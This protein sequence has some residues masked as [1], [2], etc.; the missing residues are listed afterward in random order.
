M[1]WRAYMEMMV[2]QKMQAQAYPHHTRI[3]TALRGQIVVAHKCCIE[4]NNKE[5]YCKGQAMNLSEDWWPDHTFIRSKRKQAVTVRTRDDSSARSKTRAYFHWSSSARQRPERTVIC[6]PAEIEGPTIPS[7][8]TQWG[9]KAQVFLHASLG[10]GWWFERTFIR[11]KSSH[12]LMCKIWGGSQI[13]EQGHEPQPVLKVR[14]YF[15]CRQIYPCFHVQVLQRNSHARASA[16]ERLHLGLTH[17]SRHVHRVEISMAGPRY[18]HTF[19]NDL[20]RHLALYWNRNEEPKAWACHFWLKPGTNLHIVQTTGI[21]SNLPYE[22][23]MSEHFLMIHN[24][25]TNLPSIQLY[26]NPKEASWQ[27]QRPGAQ[28][29]PNAWVSFR[30]TKMRDKSVHLPKYINQEESVRQV[31]RLTKSEGRRPTHAF[32]IHMSGISFHILRSHGDERKLPW[33]FQMLEHA[34][35]KHM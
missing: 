3:D 15:H 24:S 26:R 1:R 21:K 27:R 6:A 5:L 29:R 20:F 35:R 12:S 25:E 10:Y 33:E 14:T 22:G 31:L 11:D 23:R 13:Q 18:D 7:S 9:P 34:F 8:A 17:I 19:V 2:L 32:I 30:Q 28:R 16:L 4:A